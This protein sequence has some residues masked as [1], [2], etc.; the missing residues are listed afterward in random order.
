[1]FGR[2][3]KSDHLLQPRVGDMTSAFGFM[4]AVKTRIKKPLLYSRRNS[5]LWLPGGPVV[6]FIAKTPK[7]P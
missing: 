7:K 3:C 4:Y 2:P 1:M 6:S 5:L